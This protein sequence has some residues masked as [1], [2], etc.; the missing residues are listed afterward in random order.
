MGRN[1]L[2]RVIQLPGCHGCNLGN[3]LGHRRSQAHHPVRLDLH[4]DFLAH[5][6]PVKVSGDA[7]RFSCAAGSYERERRD[8]PHHGGGDGSREG[9][10]AACIQH[11][12]TGLDYREYLWAGLWRFP[13]A[14]GSEASGDFRELEAFQGLSVSVA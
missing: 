14:P 1:Q 12:A 11:Y 5:V 4:H 3:N 7:N 10:A 2:G 8:H 9:V 6:R 13:G